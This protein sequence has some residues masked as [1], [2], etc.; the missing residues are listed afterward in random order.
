MNRTSHL[1]LTLAFF[2]A[3]AGGTQPAHAQAYPSKPIRFIVPFPP[4]GGTDLTSR[5]LTQ[6]VSQSTGWVFVLDNKPGAGG[7]IGAEA[8]ARSAPDG[9]TLVLG[10]ASNLAINPYLY[11]KPPFDPVKDFAPVALVN[12]IPLVIL[13]SAKSSYKTLAEVIGAAKAAPER[14]TFASPGSGTV[15]H[16]AAVLLARNAGVKLTHVPYK[17]AGP[18]LTDLIGGQVDLY[19]S[20]AQAAV[21]QIKSGSVR[22]IAVTSSKRLPELP[23]V[24]TVA[25]AGQSGAEASSW[26]GVLAPAG[27]PDAIIQRLNA[28]ITKAL[29]SPELR[30]TL[31]RDGGEVLGGTPA[32]FASFLASEQARWSKVVRESGARVD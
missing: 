21:G 30:E 13:A 32:Q 17:G 24:P 25:E 3:L 6:K 22:A 1:G 14:V 26:Y 7:N 31:S 16:L 8:A 11:S 18:A 27:T 23:Q 20:T 9:Y 4:G 28:E 12:A 2:L 10:Q 15:G 29:Q 5:A 19:F